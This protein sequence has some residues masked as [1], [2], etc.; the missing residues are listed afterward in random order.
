MVRPNRWSEKQL[1]CVAMNSG[2]QALKVDLIVVGAGAFG[3]YAAGL[4]SRQR[5]SVAVVD[6]AE[7]PFTRASLVNQAR[8]HYGYHYPRSLATALSAKRYFDRFSEE[9][10]EAIN[11]DF[12]MIYATS[13]RASFTNSQAFT[14]FCDRAGIE[15][16]RVDPARFFKAGTVD[17]AFETKEC[18]FDADAL[19][20]ALMERIDENRTHWFLGHSI[21]SGIVKRDELTVRLEDGVTIRSRALVNATYSGTNAVLKA[22]GATTLP[23][24]YEL[25]EVVL[26][27][28]SQPLSGLGI[29]V[30]DGPFFSVMP[31]GLT[32]LHS[33]TAVGITP[34][35]ES[36]E[37]VPTFPC[38][39][40]VEDCTPRNL[41]D[42]TRCP[43]RP[44]T[45]WPLIRQLMELYLVEDLSMEYAHSLFTVKTV[46][47]TAEVDDSRPTVIVNHW[48]SPTVFTVFSGK[49]DT[50]F[51]L[52]S[53][54]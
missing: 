22:L 1:L 31:F 51:D 17:G 38:Q 14:A 36:R 32:G 30:M 41:A 13:T 45:G 33:A 39:P 52:E 34:R 5:R 6:I 53:V 37:E 46:L 25:C 26:G 54:V 29:T 40:L 9:F 35:L 7:T 43:Q 42:C 20:S 47:A 50:L 4:A 2:R 28:P 3:L 18:S 24:K 23:L 19:Q 27:E 44:G 15:V 16:K 11:A 12:T 49:M 48:E 21:A 10:P 8:L